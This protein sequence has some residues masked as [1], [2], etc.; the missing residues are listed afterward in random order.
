M[1][2][3]TSLVCG[4]FF[5]VAFSAILVEGGD[6]K[7]PIDTITITS[8]VGNFSLPSPYGNFT[9][10]LPEPNETLT[11]EIISNGTQAVA[12][13][14][15]EFEASITGGTGP[16][17]NNWNFG[18]GS[19]EESG[20]DGVET[21][22]HTFDV[23]DTYNVILTAIDS[24]DQTA[25]DS[26]EIMVEKERIAPTIALQQNRIAN[27]T[28]ANGAQVTYKVAAQDNV[29]GTATLEEDGSTIMQ[30]DIGGSITIYC[31]PRSG[32][33]F[34]VAGSNNS[35]A[36]VQCSATDAAGNTGTELFTLTTNLPQIPD[37]TPPA[38]VANV[39][40]FLGNNGWY[41]T[42]V[43]INWTVT[44]P[45]SL[46][47]SK[48]ESCDQTA[49]I[50]Q[51]T[52][53]SGETLTCE[54]TS[55]GGKATGSVTIK[56][57][58][59]PPVITSMQEGRTFLLNEQVS[60]DFNCTDQASGIDRCEADVSYL[61]TSSAGPHSYS[62]TA[63]DRA[64]NNHT[65][66]FTITVNLPPVTDITPPVIEESI[67]GTVGGND[68]YT[69][70]VALSWF[71]T[72]QESAVTS[73]NGCDP[74]VITQDTVGTELTCE[75]TSAGGTSNKSITIKRDVTAPVITS[76]TTSLSSGGPFEL[77]VVPADDSS[78]QA[79]DATSGIDGQGCFVSG[80]NIGLGIHT[81]TASAR[82]NAGNEVSKTI[83][84][85][86]VE[87]VDDTP[88]IIEANID[89]TEGNNGW[90]RNDVQVGWTISDSE[91]QI[92]ATNGCDPITISQ[93]TTTNGQTIICE[94]TSEGGT[95]TN[96]VI[97][98]RDAT[99]PEITCIGSE[100]CNGGSFAQGAVPS[101]PRCEATDDLSGIDDAGC[102]VSG[103]STTVTTVGDP[104][105][106]RFT[107]RD[108][109]GNEQTEEISYTVAVG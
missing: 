80:Y 22:V 91:S 83:T 67:Q 54:G 88:P 92:S 105:T 68:W 98:K 74:I 49:T 17:A 1:T 38:I 48:S 85:E 30:D 53:A 103:Y 90:Y 76:F 33:M 52:T 18:D 86:V 31:D 23:A 12:P 32:S 61:D 96:S 95:N 15:F 36:T 63:A 62:V 11:A 66:S 34:T 84:Y 46:I 94:A 79:T 44:D 102:Q 42:D 59:T 24:E 70:D 56:R 8:P 75:A 58:A 89:G 41:T 57:D 109:A 82:D 7:S 99:P 35:T 3:G 107:A 25:S 93:D 28:S 10:P 9:I 97:I 50:N 64:G 27:I 65:V 72:D 13:A 69:T 108:N 77:G 78:C 14:T 106:I 55:G 51:D 20:D 21:V 19:P 101:E 81:L 60:P 71:V 45:E 16:Y 100:I 40:G 87:P 26:L 5:I 73:Q 47:T 6:L 43:T 2:Y 37:I 4:S 104:H 39:Q 29:D